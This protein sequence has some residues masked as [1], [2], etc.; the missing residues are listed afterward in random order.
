MI[1]VLNHHKADFAVQSDKFTFWASEIEYID[2][3]DV[4]N[5]SIL[6]K[7]K[8]Q[9]RPVAVTGFNALELVWRFKPGALEG[10]RLRFPKHSWSVHNLIAH[11][12][13]QILAYFQCHRAALWIH[14]VT[15]PKPSR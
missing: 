12:V 6:V 3:S 10:K 9:E 2:V 5:Q 1:K 8:G 4:E 7:I 13:M 14:D 15:V 11:P